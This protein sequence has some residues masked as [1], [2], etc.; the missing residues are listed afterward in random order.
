MLDGPVSNPRLIS[1]LFTCG[2]VPAV[3]GCIPRS[4]DVAALDG[5]EYHLQERRL[6]CRRLDPGAAQRRL[7]FASAGPASNDAECAYGTAQAPPLG[8]AG[9]LERQECIDSHG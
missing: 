6:V 3:H 8:G 1:M 7:Q 2:L 9:D 4:R 5:P